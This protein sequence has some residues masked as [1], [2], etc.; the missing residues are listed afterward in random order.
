MT[1]S[2]SM[3][4]LPPVKSVVVYRN[5]DPFF[6]GRRFV[7]NQRQVSCMEAF[8]ND[9]TLNI[10]APLAVRTLY[11]PRNGHRVR[12]LEEMKT[13]A[14]YV[15][16]GFERF[17]RLDYFNTGVKKPL[18][19][20]VEAK[21]LVRPNVSA[22][23]RKIIPIPC[24][25]HVFRN[26]DVVG[27]PLRFILPKNMMQDLEQVLCLITEKAALRTGAVRRLYTL[28]GATV[29]TAQELVNGQCYVAVGTE[30]FKKLP[31]LELSVPKATGGSADRY[32]PLNRRQQ[33]KHENRRAGPHDTHSD[34][35]LLDSPE[36]DGRR[37]KS[38][39]DEAEDRSP[40][41]V[42]RL[43]SVREEKSVFYAKPV[44]VRK[45]PNTQR[46]KDR[47]APAAQPSVFQAQTGQRREEVLGAQE[48]PEE[49]NI[50]VDLPIDQAFAE[51]VEEEEH[52]KKDS[53]ETDHK[54]KTKITL[55]GKGSSTS[56]SD[57][58]HQRHSSSSFTAEPIQ[59]QT[60]TPENEDPSE[61]N[62]LQT[63]LEVNQPVEEE[64]SM[65]SVSRPSSSHRET[66]AQNSGCASH[67]A[68]APVDLDCRTLSPEPQED[69]GGPDRSTHSA[70]KET[71][72]GSKADLN[73]TAV[74]LDKSLAETDSQERPVSSERR[75][76]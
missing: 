23:W 46:L 7:V 14:H 38:T 43:R 28:E 53:L 35:A 41:T 58:D 55:Q 59:R 75:R 48:V 8:L 60:K 25:I 19:N 73:T 16:A 13:G 69:T 26:G 10:Q 4:V 65:I 63:D 40:G 11:T 51:T 42:Q 30:K 68:E 24:I 22:K 29:T 50:M 17:K 67:K 62:N 54:D 45:N 56:D 44:R 36:M 31:Y 34:S 57:L 76:E 3:A 37:V 33:R 47:A 5:G 12:E 64:S 2:T 6:M 39:G 74:P 72:R 18:A 20:K 32:Y 15:A 66:C 1:S 49:D 21:P 9:V 61:N 52:H 27:T 70:Q 71:P